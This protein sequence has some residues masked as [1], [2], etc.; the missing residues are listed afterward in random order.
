MVAPQDK[1]RISV[2]SEDVNIKVSPGMLKMK[3]ALPKFVGE[4]CIAVG[5]A[6]GSRSPGDRGREIESCGEKA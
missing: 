4:D 6:W 5:K 2:Q 1:E 3:A